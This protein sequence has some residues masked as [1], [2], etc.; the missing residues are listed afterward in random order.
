M[1]AT[2]FSDN[3]KPEVQDEHKKS[4]KQKP[5]TRNKKKQKQIVQPEKRYD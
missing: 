4:P 2:T 5:V 3:G 1:S